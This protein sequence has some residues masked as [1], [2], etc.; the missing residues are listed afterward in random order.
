MNNFNPKIS[1]LTAGLTQGI[2]GFGDL[3]KIEKPTKGG[4]ETI[5]SGMVQNVNQT[6]EAPDALMEQAVLGNADV[7]DVMAAISKSE[8]QV[9]LAASVTKKILQ[10][11]EKVMN[12]QI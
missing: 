7:H 11:Y 12:I 2:S 5:L 3:T 9:N 8:I 10:T 6:I 1:S 4:F